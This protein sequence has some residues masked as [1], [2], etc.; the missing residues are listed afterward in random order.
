MAFILND[1]LQPLDGPVSE[2]NEDKFRSAFDF[3]NNVNRNAVTATKIKSVFANAIQA[4]T[5]QVGINIG[6][7]SAG[8]VLI[9][10]A[11]NRIVVNDGTVDRVLIGYLANGF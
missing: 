8:Y 9:D 7:T 2:T 5:V 4:G 10:G 1:Y 11:N 3:S 6:S